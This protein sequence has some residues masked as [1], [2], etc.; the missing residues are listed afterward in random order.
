MSWTVSNY[1]TQD[2]DCQDCNHPTWVNEIAVDP[3]YTTPTYYFY[4][5]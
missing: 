1:Y 5:N 2:Y 3:G 4:C